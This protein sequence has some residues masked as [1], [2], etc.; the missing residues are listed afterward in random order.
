[1]SMAAFIGLHSAVCVS[2][3]VTLSDCA[4]HCLH[5]AAGA[6]QT[7]AGSR[8]HLLVHGV[9]STTSKAPS[10]PRLCISVA[11]HQSKSGKGKEM[12]NGHKAG[13]CLV[14]CACELVTLRSASSWSLVY[15]WVVGIY[16]SK[17]LWRSEGMSLKAEQ[18]ARH[19]EG[20][21]K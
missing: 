20:S 1:L 8:C 4:P 15:R 16:F 14:S 12:L 9:P 17:P 2:V 19:T 18:R 6:Q 13:V 7:V 3:T 10:S 11:H 5:R 21:S